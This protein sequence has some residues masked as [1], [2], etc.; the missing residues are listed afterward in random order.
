MLPRPTRQTSAARSGSKG[1]EAPDPRRGLTA[2]AVLQSSGSGRSPTDPE[3][4]LDAPG[5]LPSLDP[6]LLLKA[7]PALSLGK[8]SLRG[9]PRRPRHG[10]LRLAAEG[11]ARV[12]HSVFEPVALDSPGHRDPRRRPWPD[13]RASAPAP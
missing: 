10:V 11:A 4:P 3:T 12:L 1:R 8:P 13:R 7:E 5:L 2:S 6:G 9:L